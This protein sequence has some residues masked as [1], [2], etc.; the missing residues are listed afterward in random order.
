MLKAQADL[1]PWCYVS[2]VVAVREMELLGRDFYEELARASSDAAIHSL[3]A[4][5]PYSRLLDR[6]QDREGYLADLAAF[7]HEELEFLRKGSPDDTPFTYFILEEQY[8]QLR[9]AALAEEGSE[10]AC[11]RCEAAMLELLR[12]AEGDEAGKEVPV[13]VAALRELELNKPSRAEGISLLFDSFYLCLIDDWRTCLQSPILGEFMAAL[14]R[15][16]AA[17]A[18]L[19]ALGRG[20]AAEYID[21]YFLLGSLR[22]AEVMY[23]LHAG[24]EEAREL[25]GALAPRAMWNRLEDVSDEELLS[26]FDVEA[27]RYLGDFI[28]EAKTRP[29]GPEKVFAYLQELTWQ[30]INVQLCLG[31]ATGIIDKDIALGMLRNVHV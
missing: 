21:R 9:R 17:N 1:S 31:A 11:V 19:R 22:V 16:K 24:A 25:A 29:F 13:H 26:R 6:Q 5:T 28:R 15:V 18:M 27:D 12:I 7:Y 14:V 4:D 30:T 23:R 8:R 20:V 2:G 3:M 10:G